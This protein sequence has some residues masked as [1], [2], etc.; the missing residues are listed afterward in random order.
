MQSSFVCQLSK[1]GLFEIHC[2][3]H[4]RSQWLLFLRQ[5]LWAYQLGKFDPLG[6]VA[7]VGLID[8]LD[9]ENLV[10]YANSRG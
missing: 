4:K 7:E 3:T 10:Q 6:F 8:T 2:S 1:A 5:T 9:L